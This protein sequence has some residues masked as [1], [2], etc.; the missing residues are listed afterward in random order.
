M[1]LDAAV[2]IAVAALGAG[3]AQVA[4]VPAGQLWL[5]TQLLDGGGGF[6][7]VV[8]YMSTR[9]KKPSASPAICAIHRAATGPWQAGCRSCAYEKHL[10]CATPATRSTRRP[11]RSS[12][13]RPSTAISNAD[14]IAA[15]PGID[16]LLIGSNDLAMELGI[17]GNFGEERIAA[18]YQTIIDACKKHG[19]WAGVGGISDDALLKRYIQMGVRLVLPTGRSQLSADGRGR[20]RRD[21]AVLSVSE[22]PL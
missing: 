18:A 20:A 14:K 21:D 11:C 16:C 1:D 5:A 3:I 2:Q 15:V 22:I 13:W 17:P 7:I 4:R 10:R 6:G 19:K 9:R 8:P 12:C